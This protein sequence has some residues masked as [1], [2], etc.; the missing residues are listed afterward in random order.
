M[1]TRIKMR[2]IQIKP[3][4]SQER[5]LYNWLKSL[6]TIPSAHKKLQKLEEEPHGAWW[7]HRQNKRDISVWSRATFLNDRWQNKN[8]MLFEWPQGGDINS[9]KSRW[10]VSSPGS[11]QRWQRSRRSPKVFNRTRQPFSV[12]NT[13]SIKRDFHIY[14][15]TFHTT[16][17]QTSRVLK[18]LNRLDSELCMQARRG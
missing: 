1:R 2:L 12:Y 16:K 3:D 9:L 18:Y 5:H 6:N 8:W 13:E 14:T 7:R 4:Q 11:C 10:P 17:A 15:H